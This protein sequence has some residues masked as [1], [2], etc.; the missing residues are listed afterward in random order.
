MWTSDASTHTKT[1]NGTSTN[2]S[3]NKFSPSARG[4]NEKQ[5]PKIKRYFSVEF[6]AATLDK[7]N[8]NKMKTKQMFRLSNRIASPFFLPHSLRR[9][10]SKTK[11]RNS[12]SRFCSSSVSFFCHFASIWSFPLANFS[13][14]S[15]RKVEFKWSPQTTS[16]RLH[17][18]SFSFCFCWLRRLSSSMTSSA[19]LLTSFQFNVWR[20]RNG[21]LLSRVK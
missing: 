4:K 6:R 3:T 21:N 9:K 19:V 20:L 12:L 8:W 13:F 2:H 11:P 5:K 14:G 16:T 17:H 18:S 10:I 7:K 1:E 15:T